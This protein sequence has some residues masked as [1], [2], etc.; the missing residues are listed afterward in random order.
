MIVVVSEEPTLTARATAAA[1][2]WLWRHRSQW[3]P[4]G[5]AV[6]LWLASGVAHLIQPAAAWWLAPLL[7]VPAGMWSRARARRQTTFRSVQLLR[8]VLATLGAATAGWLVVAVAVGPARPATAVTWLALTL[9]VQTLWLLLRHT[10]A[11][12]SVPSAEE[13]R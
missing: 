2:R 5:I 6:V 9:V 7:L 12:A 8:A 11:K 10:P 4:T 1:G 13:T 3:A